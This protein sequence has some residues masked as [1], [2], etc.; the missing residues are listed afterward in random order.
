M[1]DR[2]IPRVIPLLV[3][4]SLVASLGC[5]GLYQRGALLKNQIVGSAGDQF[6]YD[7]LARNVLAGKGYVLERG[8][9]TEPGRP[10]ISRGPLYPLFLAGIYSVVDSYVL[11]RFVQVLLVA[12]IPVCLYLTG[13]TVLP[14]GWAVLL[15]VAACL[16]PFILYNE[17]WLLTESLYQVL[18]TLSFT[19][20]VLSNLHRSGRLA[21]AAGVTL[22][23]ATLTR[24]EALLL[25]AVMVVFLGVGAGWTSGGWR[26]AFFAGG[27]AL[28]LTP[29]VARNY[30]HYHR[31]VP[32]VDAMAGY[33]GIVGNHPL[34]TG[35]SWPGYEEW[36]AR[37]M[38]NYHGMRQEDRASYL[39]REIR[40]Y[41]PR[42]PR[43]LAAA[44]L[45]KFR[46]FWSPTLQT[47]TT[48][49]FRHAQKTSYDSPAVQAIAILGYGIYLPFFVLALGLAVKERAPVPLLL[50]GLVLGTMAAGVAINPSARLRSEVMPAILLLAFWGGYRCRTALARAGGRLRA[51]RGGVGS[52]GGGAQPPV[53]G[54]RSGAGS[55]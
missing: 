22:G 50:A 19:L 41:V 34:V 28:A 42:H 29:W 6:E 54:S 44:L 33:T 38:K 16:N 35:V 30:Y 47:T 39:R 9:Y 26:G 46:I 4:L 3:L 51:G 49:D 55:R 37:V 25:S 7:A 21:V 17:F 8:G 14:E 18:L 40:A 12:L 32:T 48:V 53:C 2:R 5:L 20:A 23:L 27:L 36:S 45:A 13:R 24:S 31:F 10:Y 43:E 11:V 52:S 15:A 1:V